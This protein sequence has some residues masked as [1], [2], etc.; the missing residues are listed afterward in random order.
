[1]LLAIRTNIMVTVL[2][3]VLIDDGIVIKYNDKSTLI[4]PVEPSH[5][6]KWIMT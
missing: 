4:F 5:Y 2:K 1:M 6:S 3:P